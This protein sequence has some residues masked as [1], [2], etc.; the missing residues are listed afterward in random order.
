MDI[1][2]IAIAIGAMGTLIV[3]LIRHRNVI[4]EYFGEQRPYCTRI[5]HWLIFGS[6]LWIG[7]LVGIIIGDRQIV[8]IEGGPSFQQ[9]EREP[10]RVTPPDQQ[11]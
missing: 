4:G 7:L 9:E 10:E 2:S 1:T 8:R 6:A 11:R 5:T 3:T